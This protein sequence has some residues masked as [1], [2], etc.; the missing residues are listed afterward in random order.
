MQ[1]RTDYLAARRTLR[2]NG[3]YAL[4]WMT[5]DDAQTM[6]RLIDAPGDYLGWRA[7]MLRDFGTVGAQQDIRYRAYCLRTC[8]KYTA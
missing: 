3:R 6:R 8:R 5:A 1:T 4:R 7:G 2:D